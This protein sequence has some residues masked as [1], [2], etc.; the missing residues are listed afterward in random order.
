MTE[1][2]LTGMLSLVILISRRQEA[3]LPSIMNVQPPTFHIFT[4]FLLNDP[5]FAEVF[6]LLLQKLVK[7]L[8]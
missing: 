2:L 3:K 8:C 7:R 5:I 6:S 4:V 1:K